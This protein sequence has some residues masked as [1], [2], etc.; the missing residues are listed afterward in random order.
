MAGT[1]PPTVE[2][3]NVQICVAVLLGSLSETALSVIEPAPVPF[4]M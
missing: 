2:S 3:P 4:S 1:E